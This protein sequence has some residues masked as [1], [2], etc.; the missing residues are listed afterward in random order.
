MVEVTAYDS[1]GDDTDPVA[2]V[3]INV[4]DEEEKPTFNVDA[5]EDE[6]VM[7]ATVEE[8]RNGR[9][10]ERRDLHGYGPGG[11]ER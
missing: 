11:R 8:K 5:T 2:T 7:G 4:I 9:C 3:T 1:S 10:L 6:N